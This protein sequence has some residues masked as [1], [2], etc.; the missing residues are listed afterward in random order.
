MSQTKAK[1]MITSGFL[2][3][4][5]TTSMIAF[6]NVI[7]KRYGKAAILVNDLGADNIVDA[8]F[9]ATTDI[10]TTQ[11]S[12]DCI[13]YQHENLVD[14]LNQL[15]NG[16]ATVIMSD[17]PGCGIGALEHVYVQLEERRPGEFDL[18]PFTCIV[19]PERLRMLMPE[20]EQINLPAEMRFLLEAQMAEADLIVL[21]KI[22]LI[23]AEERKKR[24]AFIKATFPDTPVFAMSAL[25]GE[26]V[27]EVVDY[28]MTHKAAAVYREIGYGSEAFIAAENLLSW[29]NRRVFFE[30][31]NDKNIDFNEVVGDLFKQIRKGLKVNHDN[32][33]H[34]KAFA[35]G[36]GDDFVKASLIG[37]D[38]DV[39][40]DQRLTQPYSAISLIINARAVAD[41]HV[42]ADIV[43][44]ALATV[45]DKYNLQ[46]RTFFVETFGMMEEGKGDGGRASRYE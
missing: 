23:S 8:N 28:L 2:G 33:P 25:T 45:A 16:G 24:M 39:E 34:L 11:I 20:E 38:Y 42:M 13:C 35:A 18:M 32:V 44:D 41:S 5:K 26:G 27:D 30:E 46:S 22:D 1:Y 31:K 15:I 40:Y 17:I 10:L 43:E 4:G 19:D 12:G 3:A 14:K 37:V 36:K 29:Y 9:T 6:G 21:N 7:D